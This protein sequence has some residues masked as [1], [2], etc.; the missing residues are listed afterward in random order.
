MAVLRLMTNSNLV[1]R[2]HRQIARLGALE[3]AVDIGGRAPV[4]IGQIATIGHQAAARGEVPIGVDGGQSMPRRKRDDQ[5]AMVGGAH[6]RQ[7]HQAAI[8]MARE[9]R[10]GA[11]DLAD[12]ANGRLH[13]LDVKGRS[14]V[15]DRLPEHA[16][17]TEPCPG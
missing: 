17:R 13:R 12:V 11:L 4:D 2:L 15:L 8:R 16:G 3:N 10:D 1:R 5:V 14:R 9:G 7:D 6:V